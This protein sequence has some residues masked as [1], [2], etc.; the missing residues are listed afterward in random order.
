[1]ENVEIV[2]L[3]TVIR[4]N[5]FQRDKKCQVPFQTM[6]PHSLSLFEISGS[7]ILQHIPI[8]NVHFCQIN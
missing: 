2:S 5:F 8:K 4:N 6:K 3:R 1:M 7:K